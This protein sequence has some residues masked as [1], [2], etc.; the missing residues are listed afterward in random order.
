MKILQLKNFN[1]FNIKIYKYNINMKIIIGLLVSAIIIILCISTAM[2][3]TPKLKQLNKIFP[4]NMSCIHD[5]C[6][7][8]YS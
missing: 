6:H 8:V 4:L 3:Y 1:K 5:N 7:S 2:G